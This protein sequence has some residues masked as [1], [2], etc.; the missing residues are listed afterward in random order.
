M[1][2]DYNDKTVSGFSLVDDRQWLCK[3]F[4]E[5]QPEIQK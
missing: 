4:Q 2:V 5:E 1:I 3:L